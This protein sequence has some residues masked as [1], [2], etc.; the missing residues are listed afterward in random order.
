MDY[1]WRYVSNL[2]D[3]VPDSQILDMRIR[4][5]PVAKQTFEYVH[6]RWYRQ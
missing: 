4:K 6:A 1:V 3:N 5:F 2:R